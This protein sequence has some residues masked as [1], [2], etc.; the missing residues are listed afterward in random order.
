MCIR[1][2]LST[3]LVTGSKGEPLCECRIDAGA[4]ELPP[5]WPGRY[6]AALHRA[7]DAM[8]ALETVSYTHLDVYK[9]QGYK[10]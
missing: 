1:D 8:I 7:H 10:A 2:R 6:G 5:D 3:V 4:M 9:R